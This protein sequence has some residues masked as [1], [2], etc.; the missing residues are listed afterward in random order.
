MWHVIYI[1]FLIL[2][3]YWGVES[4]LGPLGTAA[5]TGLLYLPRVI[6]RM[7]KLVEWTVLAGETEVL[8][9][10]LPCHHF[11]HHKSH[12]PDPGVKPGHRGGKPATNCFSYGAAS[13]TYYKQMNTKTNWNISIH[14]N[15]KEVF[16]VKARS[17]T[18]TKTFCNILTV[19]IILYMGESCVLTQ[20]YKSQ[21]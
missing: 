15:V 10:N 1:S 6:V 7:K 21:I 19:Y 2:F 14:G 20:R 8:E 18:K 5:I 11:V 9:E 17:E 13:F 16:S 3:E 12:L 4:I